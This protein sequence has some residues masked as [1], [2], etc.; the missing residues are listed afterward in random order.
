MFDF[1]PPE[2]WDALVSAFSYV[3]L[4]LPIWLPI[5][6]LIMLFKAWIYYRRGAYWQ[7]LGSVLLEIKLPREIFKS[8]L[9]MELVLSS[10]H[11][12]SDESNWYQKY[13]L[14]Q[15]RSWFSLELVSIGGDIR[16]FI[17]C[18]KKY[19]NSIEGHLYSQYPGVEVYEADDYTKDIY[20]D[21]EK[22]DLFGAQW[23][24]AKPDPF[25]IKTYI[26]YG[27]DKDPKE[28]YKVDPLATSLEFLSTVNAGHNIWIQIIIRAHKKESRKALPWAKKLEKFAWSEEV[29]SWKEEAKT[30]VDK[31]IKQ[32]RPEEKDKPSRQPT[33]GEKDTIGALER[34][35]GKIPFDVSI[36]SIYFANKDI[37][38][39]MYIG[40]IFGYFKQY[41]SAEFNGFKAAG[42]HTEFGNPIYDWWKSTEKFPYRLL[43]E[44]KLRRFFFSPFKGKWF[45]SKPFVLNSEELATIY[46]FPGSIAAAP[47]FERVPSK[48]SNAPS[49][50]PI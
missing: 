49:N 24:L 2:M 34:S 9:A 43:D 18:R 22:H 3:Y 5:V 21:P 23:E 27:L 8:P 25:P 33:E 12:T 10:M 26:D 38:N 17:W 36:R 44:Y 16:F 6:F 15:T 50:L 41:A 40:G 1:I 47:T 30:E 31:I 35:I 19:K 32:F 48:K 29:D 13:W 14:G 42:W 37:Y 7:G 39:K 28:E 4:T 11:Q 45:Y 20:F 46:H